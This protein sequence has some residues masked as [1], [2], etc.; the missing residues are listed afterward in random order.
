MLTAEQQKRLDQDYLEYIDIR[1]EGR[2][3]AGE[4]F[5]EL[6]M[7]AHE[8][9]TDYCLEMITAEGKISGRNKIFL[10]LQSH[11]RSER[12]YPSFNFI[13]PIIQQFVDSL[14]S[15][16]E[17][18]TYLMNLRTIAESV[19]KYE[20][21]HCSQWIKR[22]IHGLRLE[23]K[24]FSGK[25]AR[26]EV[27]PAKRSVYKLPNEQTAEPL[28]RV[29]H[30]ESEIKCSL[31]PIQ[32]IGPKNLLLDV[33]NLLGR[34]NLISPLCLEN[35]LDLIVGHFVD[36]EGQPFIRKNLLE[37]ERITKDNKRP[38]HAGRPKMGPALEAELVRLMNGQS[39]ED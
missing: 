37:L 10:L 36:R 35:R 28:A 14:P 12:L 24:T 22:R 29:M 8:N 3:N 9:Y 20:A 33:F 4:C 39:T 34:F 16:D 21:N 1:C 11:M 31:P 2:E 32:W 27:N 15:F 7:L 26:S 23:A 6:Q 17:K 19:N 18:V 5:A 38:E 13:V 30:A 25:T